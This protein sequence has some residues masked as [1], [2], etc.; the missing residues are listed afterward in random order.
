M[1]GILA[2]T[3]YYLLAILNWSILMLFLVSVAIFITL[4]LTPIMVSVSQ[5]TLFM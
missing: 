1:N 2:N 4:N 5:Q 3:K